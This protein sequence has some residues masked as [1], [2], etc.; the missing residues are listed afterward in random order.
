[1]NIPERLYRGTGEYSSW[2]LAS[3]DLSLYEWSVYVGYTGNSRI[4]EVSSPKSSSYIKVMV[5]GSTPRFTVFASDLSIETY[6]SIEMALERL[7]WS[8][9][10]ALERIQVMESVKVPAL[11]GGAL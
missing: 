5:A 7:E 9:P 8:E 6:N 3:Y 10:S 11:Q 4:A 2:T 1:M